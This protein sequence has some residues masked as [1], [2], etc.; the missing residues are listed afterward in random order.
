[1]GN[2]IILYIPIVDIHLHRTISEAITK[3]CVQHSSEKDTVDHE[4]NGSSDLQSCNSGGL[5]RFPGGL[6]ID[7]EIN[8]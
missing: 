7:D 2:S 5:G 4:G 3:L 6:H 8:G 1:M